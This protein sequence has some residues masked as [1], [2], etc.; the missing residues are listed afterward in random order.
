MQ[1]VMNVA[2]QGAVS[3]LER[4]GAIDSF[5]V[6]MERSMTQTVLADGTQLIFTA[7]TATHLILLGALAVILI[8]ALVFEW[9]A[10]YFM[11]NRL[12]LA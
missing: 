4:M 2:A 7:A 1:F 9:I 12:N 11:K 3:L 8:S 5:S 10:A 6:W